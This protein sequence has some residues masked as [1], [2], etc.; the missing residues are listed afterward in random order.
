M[1]QTCLKGKVYLVRYT[2]CHHK[3]VIW[4]KFA[5]LDDLPKMAKKFEQEQGHELGVKRIQKKKE[6]P[7]TSNQNVDEDINL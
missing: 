7:H 1:R 4:M 3:E 6:D 5:H 2:G